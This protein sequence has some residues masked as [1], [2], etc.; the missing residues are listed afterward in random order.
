MKWQEPWNKIKNTG[1]K[2]EKETTSVQLCMY[3][4]RLKFHCPG[5][6]QHTSQKRGVQKAGFIRSAIM[7]KLHKFFLKKK[8]PKMNKA[9]QSVNCD[10]GLH[11]FFLSSMTP[12]NLLATAVNNTMVCKSLTSI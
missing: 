7:K 3:S 9:L 11:I 2:R 12:T 5:T 6:L 10:H 8:P 4:T 1:G